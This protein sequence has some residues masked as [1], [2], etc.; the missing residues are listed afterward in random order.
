MA[1]AFPQVTEQARRWHGTAAAEYIRI[2]NLNA[3]LSDGET[4]FIRTGRNDREFDPP[5]WT[6]GVTHAQRWQ[7]VIDMT[8][9]VTGDVIAA[10]RVFVTTPEMTALSQAAQILTGRVLEVAWEHLL[11]RSLEAFRSG[12]MWP[13]P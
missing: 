7:Y 12:M 9:T 8:H 11:N 5:P 4:C 6:D 13:L 1:A 10:W 3:Y 2:A